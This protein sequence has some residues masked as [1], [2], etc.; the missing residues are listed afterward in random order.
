MNLQF[1][2][3]FSQPLRRKSF[4]LPVIRKKRD[5]R[6]NIPV[7]DDVKWVDREKKKQLEFIVNAF[8]LDKRLSTWQF[9]YLPC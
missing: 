8:E 4:K 6:K 1:W 9:I 3:T 5:L 7:S 2:A